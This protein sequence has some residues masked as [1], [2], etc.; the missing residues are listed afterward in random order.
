[1]RTN[2]EHINGLYSG[3][4]KRW[5]SMDYMIS[6][7]SV[8]LED[9]S[10]AEI[11]VALAASLSEF[12][13]KSRSI[14][15]VLE[16]DSVAFQE[17]YPISVDHIEDCGGWFVSQ[18]DEVTLNN[19]CLMP[20]NDTK[21]TASKNLSDVFVFNGESLIVP[22][23]THSMV[24]GLNALVVLHPT[25]ASL[26]IPTRLHEIYGDEIR[27]GALSKLYA[28]RMKPWFQPGE[29]R[30]RARILK[31]AIAR[32]RAEIYGA[33]VGLQRPRTGATREFF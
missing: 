5:T 20:P 29:S 18:V 31:T 4:Q 26:K 24:N 22:Q 3:W 7:I 14:I 21:L 27:E 33:H 16:M 11:K 30:R 2:F 15:E 13:Q 23:A 10:D 9:A 6:A 1:M 25:V 19:C 17:V 28:Q 32:A 8:E 12:A